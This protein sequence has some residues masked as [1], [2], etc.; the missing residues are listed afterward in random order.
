MN[1]C[2]SSRAMVSW[3][4]LSLAL[5]AAP[6]CASGS[7]FGRALTLADQVPA[8]AA[9]NAPASERLPSERSDDV[10]SAIAAYD[11]L[12]AGPNAPQ[13][14][15][16]EVIAGIWTPRAGGRARFGRGSV[17]EFELGPGMSLDDKELTP[18]L[19]IRFRPRTEWEV[20]FGGFRFSTKESNGTF[21]RPDVQFGSVPLAFGENFTSSLDID[22]VN[23]EL[24]YRGWRIYDRERDGGEADFGFH[25]TIGTR[26]M[27]VRHDVERAG[28]GRERGGGDYG[29]VTFGGQLRLHWSPDGG[30]P[31]THGI[32]I[33]IAGAIGPAFGDGSG[34]TWHVR[35]GVRFEIFRNIDIMIAYR[36]LEMDV[37][38]GSEGYRFVGGLQGM[39]FTVG[40]RF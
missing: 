32:G 38:D 29:A 5:L 14:V 12:S 39:F 18:N 35:S 13:R 1:V 7:M 36:L 23:L 31:V 37:R 17:N 16:L 21:R 26:W 10:A 19:E 4:V 25:P 40:A 8:L 15:R 11:D 30:L 22:S 2:P 28:F 33:E 6:V 20:V 27:R 24:T 34:Y 9:A 3:T